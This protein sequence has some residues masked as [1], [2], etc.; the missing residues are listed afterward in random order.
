MN[1]APD[2]NS[3][4]SAGA[5]IELVAGQRVGSG[6]Y[7]LEKLLGQGGMGVVWLARDERLQQHVALKFL[8]AHIQSDPVALDDMRRETARSI[9]LSH[10]NIVRIHDLHEIEGREAFISMEYV[11]GLTLHALRVEQP[12]RVFSWTFLQ[13]LVKQLCAAMDYAH[14]ERVIHRD[15]K[16]ANMMLD[17]R[18]RLKLADFGIAALVSDSLSRISLKRPTSGTPTHMSPQQMNGQAPRVTDDIYSLGASLYELLTS[19]PPFYTGDITHQVLDV[20]AAPMADRLGELELTNEIPPEVAAMVMACL[21]KE[22]G[23]RP[24]SAR[25]VA[26]WIGLSLDTDSKLRGPDTTSASASPAPATSV[27][28]GLVATASAL[29]ALVRTWRPM[30]WGVAALALLGA[31]G[32][33]W[34][35]QHRTRQSNAGEAVGHNTRPETSL[36]SGTRPGAAKEAVVF[37]ERFEDLDAQGKPKLW[38]WSVTNAGSGAKATTREINGNHFVQFEATGSDGLIAMWLGWRRDLALDKR[39]KALR[40][41]A[42]IKTENVHVNPAWDKLKG[43]FFNEV[44]KDEKWDQ[45]KWD[46][47]APM[48][49]DTDWT[50]I[51]DVQSIPTQA[52]FVSIVFQLMKA[53]GVMAIDD[54]KVSAIEGKREEDP[55][56]SSSEAA[57]GFVSLFNGRDLSGWEEF[58][59]EG[60]EKWVVKEGAVTSV[61]KRGKDSMIVWRGGLVD[62]FELRFS[63]KLGHVI[64][65][66]QGGCAVIYRETRDFDT[67]NN[68]VLAKDPK[69]AY[70]IY[71]GGP[72]SRGQGGN[73]AEIGQN[74][75]ATDRN[76]Q[77]KLSVVGLVGSPAELAAA[78]KDADWNDCAIIVQGHHHIYKVNGRTMIEFT[79]ENLA[80]RTSRGELHL[81]LW[82]GER[83]PPLAVQFK[84]MRLKR[85][86]VQTN[87]QARLVP[88]RDPA[89][90][91]RCIDLTDYY[92]VL[93]TES[94][95]AGTGQSD[96]SEVPRGFHKFGDVEFDVRGLIQVGA[97]SRTAQ[98]YPEQ[99]SGI[100]VN[101]ACRF[102]H[103][104]H[105]AIHA[106][107]VD[108]PQ[109]GSYVVHYANGN[110]REIPIR[111]GEEVADWFTP[112]NEKD[113][114]FVI[115]WQGYNPESRL[116]GRR[117]RLF[118]TR[119]PNPLPDTPITSI[120][121]AHK[122]SATNEWGGNAAPF[123]V[124]LTTEG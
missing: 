67:R 118:S 79:D 5:R 4:E 78:V 113:Q 100:R 107:S 18:G 23:Q 32:L 103:F 55:S 110:Q 86:P 120:E 40:I 52:A 59:N 50:T 49:H 19:R 99:I 98:K 48:S 13:P 38:D 108:G 39:W 8:P 81:F 80:K 94:W 25:A 62:D 75:I 122:P 77:E 42:R 53:S 85:F 30:G 47:T 72:M 36:A 82:N 44:W 92:N 112:P 121:F 60:W 91:A 31:F 88:P 11:E 64:S 96:L 119:W 21:A 68:P 104:L 71:L 16:P 41:S 24:Q 7:R 65:D 101:R 43:V 1:L 29:S 51:E 95:H 97:A 45:I 76:G 56:V 63:Y 73:L 35:I 89:T 90:P 57:E 106:T 15:L 117:I 6:R 20:P 12:N 87:T 116:E 124:A 66:K 115:A 84:N 9:R 102:L 14:G 58:W 61:L 33:Y 17:A 37:E 74:V 22:P 111:L 69:N 123:L 10:P 2:A 70:D 3:P 27:G 114:H 54:L 28:A 93:L 105:A 46:G 26:D 34:T 109:I 83:F